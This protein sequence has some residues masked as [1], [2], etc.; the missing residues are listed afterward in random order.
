[1]ST[2]RAAGLADEGP[3]GGGAGVTPTPHL[4]AAAPPAGPDA[5]PRAASE[6][7]EDRGGGAKGQP[8]VRSGKQ[9]LVHAR[10]ARQHAGPGHAHSTPLP[11]PPAGDRPGHRARQ[12][13][14]V[15]RVRKRGA[16]R[17]E[18]ATYMSSPWRALSSLSEACLIA[19]FSLFFFSFF[20]FLERVL[21]KFWITP[22]FS[23]FSGPLL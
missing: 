16:E 4:G 19:S 8:A 1:M 9:P 5:G 23:C 13:G 3:G 14:E 15:C 12:L 21:L 7:R 20:S 2:P 10:T 11:R 18:Q 17:G 22:S 6:A